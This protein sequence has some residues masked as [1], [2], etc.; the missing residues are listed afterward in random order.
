[1]LTIEK[2]N[3]KKKPYLDAK[4]HPTFDVITIALSTYVEMSKNKILMKFVP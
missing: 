1:M 4:N 2:L 3:I